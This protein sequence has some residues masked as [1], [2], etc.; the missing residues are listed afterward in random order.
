MT[1]FLTSL[2]RGIAAPWLVAVHAACDVGGGGG[3]GCSGGFGGGGGDNDVRW[4]RVRPFRSGG[5]RFLPGAG[6]LAGLGD[7]VCARA[8]CTVSEVVLEVRRPWR[9]VG[10]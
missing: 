9:R 3:G 2:I 5:R 8:P 7:G 4:R 6:A 10:W 1:E